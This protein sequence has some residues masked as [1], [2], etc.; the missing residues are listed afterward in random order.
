MTVVEPQI[1]PAHAVRITV[2]GATPETTPLF[3][4]SL[5]IPLLLPESLVTVATVLSEEV[6]IADASCT[7]L[8]SLKIP[9]VTSA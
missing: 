6:Q 3:V 2:P 8:L 5:V 9:I 7:L 4:E 1:V